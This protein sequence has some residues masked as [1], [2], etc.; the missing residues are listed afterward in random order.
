[1]PTV[2]GKDRMGL[3]EARVNGE[4]TGYVIDILFRMLEPEE[5]A[6]AMGFDG[7]E[8]KGTKKQKVL[9]IGNAVEVNMAEALCTAV[10]K[11]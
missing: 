11:P 7:H 1:M 3:V 4:P 10:L 5:L 9:M 8:F 2:T 6:Q